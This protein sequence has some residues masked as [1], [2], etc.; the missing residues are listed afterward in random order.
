MYEQNYA[1]TTDEN[2]MTPRRHAEAVKPAAE[3]AEPPPTVEGWLWRKCKV[4]YDKGWYQLLGGDL[5]Y[6]NQ[7]SAGQGERLGKVSGSVVTSAERLEFTIYAEYKTRS[8]SFRVE[9]QEELAQWMAACQER[10]SVL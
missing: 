7:E 9:S 6:G 10:A 4:T 8:F 2:A 3:A 1:A 5:I